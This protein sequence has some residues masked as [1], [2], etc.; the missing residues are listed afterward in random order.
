MPD[1]TPEL[2]LRSDDPPSIVLQPG[3]TPSVQ[4]TAPAIA[5]VNVEAP[6]TPQ[7]GVREPSTPTLNIWGPTPGPQGERGETGA[8]GMV[9][10]SLTIEQPRHNEDVLVMVTLE[11]MALHRAVISFRGTGS[12]TFSIWHGESQSQPLA[13]IEDRTVDADGP[14]W[15]AYTPSLPIPAGNYVWL[16]TSAQTPSA[17]QLFINLDLEGA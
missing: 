5:T 11:D 12:V 14:I 13:I 16:T 15:I 8:R 10:R 3:P 1:E 2:L 9:S 7:V 4:V 17:D 6:S